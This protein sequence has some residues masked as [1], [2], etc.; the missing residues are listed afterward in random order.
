MSAKKKILVIQNIHQKGIDLLKGNPNYEFE[1]FDEINEDLKKEKP[2]Y[3]DSVIS[4]SAVNLDFFQKV[5]CLAP[6]G[7]GNPEPRFM[8]ENLNTING[9]VVGDKHV[10]SIL[11]GKDGS[12]IKSIAFNATDNDLIDLIKKRTN[13]YSK[14]LYE[15]KCD[16]L[17][18]NEIVSKIK[19]IYETN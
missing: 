13:I 10:K 15:I 17:T 16:N 18:K 7:S 19:E 4:S 9:K 1:I 6:F 8:I 2:L 11:I 5:N 14:A 12:T 3:L